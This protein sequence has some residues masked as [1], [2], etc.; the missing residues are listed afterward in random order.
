MFAIA[1]QITQNLG[2]G[3]RH[4]AR[5][6]QTMGEKI[7]QP[8]GIVDVSLAARHVLDLSGIR[9]HQLKIAITE[10]MPDRLPVDA[11]RLHGHHGT[12]LGC[13]PVRQ[14]KKARG[15]GVERADFPLDRTVHHVPHAGD[16]RLLVHIQTGAMWV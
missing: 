4:E 2:V 6:D 12:A 7:C 8:G 13:Q 9:Q 11:G 5:S 15:G 1:Q 16:H 14:G 10:D 3:I